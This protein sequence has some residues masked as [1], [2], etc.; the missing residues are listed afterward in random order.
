MLG[1]HYFAFA[2]FCITPLNKQPSGLVL[3]MIHRKR[4]L[5]FALVIL[6]LCSMALARSRK[7]S[8]E[9]EKN[10]TID[11]PH[12]HFLVELLG[13]QIYRAINTPKYKFYIYMTVG[14][15]PNEQSMVAFLST[16][17]NVL[18]GCIVAFGFLFLRRDYMLLVTLLTL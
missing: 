17:C 6:C 9:A 13:K 2:S 3:D 11:A 12:V 18:Y 1:R 14:K 16:I 4:F 8:Q 15:L 7:A 10:E 5:L